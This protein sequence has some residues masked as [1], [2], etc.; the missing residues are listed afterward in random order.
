MNIHKIITDNSAY[1]ILVYVKPIV[2][3]YSRHELLRKK[4]VEKVFLK[5]NASKI[6]FFSPVPHQPAL[7]NDKMEP[8]GTNKEGEKAQLKNELIERLRSDTLQ[9]QQ[10]VTR[11]EEL[12]KLNEK[13]EENQFQQ[14]Q[15]GTL[16]IRT[17]EHFLRLLFVFNCQCNDLFV[18]EENYT[19]VCHVMIPT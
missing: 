9:L 12:L 2:T 7:S 16:S 19:D 10:Q 3:A 11:L 6:L 18:D 4:K 14:V 17:A 8:W 1:C 5:I 13:G 15:P